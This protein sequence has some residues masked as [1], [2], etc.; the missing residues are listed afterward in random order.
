VNVIFDIM[1]ITSNFRTDPLILT[2]VCNLTTKVLELNAVKYERGILARIV[3]NIKSCTHLL[4]YL[5]LQKYEELC[6][7]AKKH[8]I[9][10]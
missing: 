4:P 9:G 5:G 1:Q 2:A 8:Q 3:N 6:K 10:L 7:S